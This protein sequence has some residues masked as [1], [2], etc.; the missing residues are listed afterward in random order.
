MRI[1]DPNWAATFALAA[2][3]AHRSSPSLATIEGVHKLQ[4]EPPPLYVEFEH[5]TRHGSSPRRVEGVEKSP[6]HREPS[7]NPTCRQGPSGK[8]PLALHTILN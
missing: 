1:L 6:H 3:I 8:D 7:R 4:E 2:A 5:Q